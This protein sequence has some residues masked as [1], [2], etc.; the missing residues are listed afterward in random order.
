MLRVIALCP[1]REAQAE[2]QTMQVENCKLPKVLQVSTIKLSFQI[3]QCLNFGSDLQ[4]NTNGF[5]IH[6]SV[7][8]HPSSVSVT[9]KKTVIG[10]TSR[11]LIATIHFVSQRLEFCCYRNW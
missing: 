10:V 4:E 6:D 11:L 1:R 7:D 3:K 8:Q 2:W 9:E 5:R